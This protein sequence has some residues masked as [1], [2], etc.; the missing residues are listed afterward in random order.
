MAGLVTMATVDGG[1]ESYMKG[2]GF[3]RGAAVFLGESLGEAFLA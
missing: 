1:N 3:W 2:K